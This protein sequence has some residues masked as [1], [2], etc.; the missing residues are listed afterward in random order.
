MLSA[1]LYALLYALRSFLE[2]FQ[3][4][5]VLLSTLRLLI[6]LSKL[7]QFNMMPSNL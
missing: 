7:M 3:S 2:T 1:L 6:R 5:W 4:G